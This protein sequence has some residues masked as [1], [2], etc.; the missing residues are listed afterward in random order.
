LD[1]LSSP[2]PVDC[3]VRQEPG[4]VINDLHSVC[5]V[6]CC[7]KLCRL[8]AAVAEVLNLWLNLIDSAL[9]I[10]SVKL[11]SCASCASCVPCV[12]CVVGRAVNLEDS[13]DVSEPPAVHGFE[14][15]PS[16]SAIVRCKSIASD[17]CDAV[18]S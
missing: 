7:A 4:G 17:A 12:L 6:F 2:D 9:S 5:D 15:K 3:L 8:E 18:R 11:T 10:W 16:K 1:V 13:C 14:D